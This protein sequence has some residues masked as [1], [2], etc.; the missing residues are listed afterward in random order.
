MAPEGVRPA[1]RT[2][3]L[4]AGATAL[5]AGGEV[6]AA[7][8]REYLPTSPALEIGGAFGPEGGAQLRFAVLGDSTAAGVGAGSPGLSYPALLAERLGRD[9]YRVALIDLG[10]SGARVADL[11][12]DQAPR[13]AAMAPDLVLVVMG[14]NDVTHVTPL[15]SV[16]RDMR[17]ALRL[18]A[19]TGPRVVVTGVPDMRARA[20]LQPLRTLAGWRGKAV[21]RAIEGVAREAAVPFVPLAELTGHFFEEDPDGH[22]SADGFHPGPGGYARWADAISPALFEALDSS[23]RAGPRRSTPEP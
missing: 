12:R 4:L 8:R 22:Y 5:V 9:G 11:P 19:A 3:L 20:F 6:V 15:R 14:A 2:V 13:A 17:A 23:R 10:L 21:S 16:R 1:A 18:L 7:L